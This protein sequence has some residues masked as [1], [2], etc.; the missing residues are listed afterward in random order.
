MSVFAECGFAQNN[1]HVI[2]SQ[3]YAAGG[4][5]G[6]VLNADYVELFNPTGNTLTLNNY[7]IQYASAG[8][9]TISTV[10][11]LPATIT[12]A[13]G[14][15]Y[16]IAASAGDHWRG[17]SG[18]AGRSGHEYCLRSIGGKGGS[19]QLDRRSWPAAC[20]TSDPTVVDFIAYGSGTNCSLGSPAPA[21]STTKAD[22]RSN[23]CTITNNSGM[24]FVAGTPAPHNSASTPMVCGAPTP[25][26]CLWPGDSIDRLFGQA[27]PC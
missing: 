18:D 1:T 26:V 22:I 13:P 14:Q 7:S 25:L 21:P 19:G 6:A 3:I 11:V 12:L 2:I 16:L 9:A 24:E 10:T 4:N 27:P 17:A 8:G 5:N 20:K 23:V 15:F